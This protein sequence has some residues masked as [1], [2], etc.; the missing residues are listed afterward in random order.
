LIDDVGDIAGFY[1]EDPERELRRLDEHQLEYELT[2]RYLDQ[3]LP[4]KGS[5]LDVGAGTGRYA[6]K[7]A[8]RGY[9]VTAA[10]LS[11]ALVEECERGVREQ[12]LTDR[13]QV[14]I[15]DARDLHALPPNAFDAVLMLGPLY[16]LVEESDR[17]L[18]LRQARDRLKPGALIFAALLSR[19]GVLADLVRKMPEWIDDSVHVQSLLERGRRPD[20]S[21]P[22][23]FRGYFAR[24]SEIVPMH[25]AV[26]FETLTLAAVEPIIGADDESFNRLEGRQRE[27]WL[28]VFH[29]ISTDSSVVGASRHVLY[30]GRKTG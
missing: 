21:A 18:A 20:G 3:Y 11:P 13:V 16:H 24:V 15:A 6:I 22:G 4:P 8:E 12:Q 9:T 27:E 2:L 17:Q 19:L 7:L 26:G 28:E 23:G 30:V 29:E 10:D 25:E 5:I 14:L 1:D